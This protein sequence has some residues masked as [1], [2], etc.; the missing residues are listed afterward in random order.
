[1]RI[2]SVD[3][4]E[5]GGQSHAWSIEDLS[6]IDV[7]LIVG[8]NATG[9][10]R[11]LR[12]ISAAA[13]LIE[14]TLT[15]A[16]IL[17]GKYKF[18]LKDDPIVTDRKR[19]RGEPKPDVVYSLEIQEGRVLSEVLEIGGVE[20][21]TRAKTGRGKVFFEKNDTYIDVQIPEGQLAATTRRDL[22][23][24]SFFEDLHSWAASVRYYETARTE[25]NTYSAFQG[26]LRRP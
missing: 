4:T 10:S 11:V 13:R 22:E 6:F 23:Q 25:A 12:V 15:P 8:K 20:K 17:T 24:H 2:H 1:M 9:K 18:V 16:N 19:S 14:G 26:S 3:Y 21:L 7:N 5:Y